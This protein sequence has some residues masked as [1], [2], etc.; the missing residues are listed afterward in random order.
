MDMNAS[1]LDNLQIAHR[2]IQAACRFNLDMCANGYGCDSM[3][4]FN[5]LVEGMAQIAEQ[6]PDLDIAG[7]VEFYELHC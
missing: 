2:A 1:P 6:M 3:Y 4:T 5:D 7:I